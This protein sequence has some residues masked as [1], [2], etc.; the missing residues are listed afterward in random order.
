MWPGQAGSKL[1]FRSSQS[2]ADCQDTF[3]NDHGDEM[4]AAGDL[5]IG[6]SSLST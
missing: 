5:E 4:R 1:Y 6:G 2:Q 3:R